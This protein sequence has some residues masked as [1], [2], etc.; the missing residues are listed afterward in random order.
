MD[1]VETAE[2]RIRDFVNVPRRRSRL[3][4]NEQRWMQLCSSMDAIGDTQLAVRAFL[5]EPLRNRKSDGWSY[6]VVYGVLQVLY[7][8]QDA[9]KM[10]ASCLNLP[11]EFPEEVESIREIRNDS[12]GH[13]SGRGALISRITLTPEGFRLLVKKKR[14]RMEFPHVSVRDAAEQQTAVM[15]ALL[16]TMAE[17]LMSDELAHRKQFRDQPLRNAV[18]DSLGY[19]TEKIGAGL[20]RPEERPMALGG[21]EVITKALKKLREA[22]KQ[23]GL[24]DAYK[25]SVGQTTAEVEFALTR[26]DARLKGGLPEWTQQDADVYWFFLAEKLRELQKM[27]AEIDAEYASDEVD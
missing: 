25:D 9:A 8:Q 14:G 12:I 22:V 26:I 20:S 23:R 10:L 2:K 11:L 15:G 18:P 21:I 27:A 13:P 4:Q 24:T 7:V 6:L 5:D 16:N 3:L 17:Q 1:P 19:A